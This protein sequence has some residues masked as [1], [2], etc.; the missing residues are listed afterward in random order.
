MSRG[1]TS[2]AA[3]QCKCQ[4]A[5][6]A[7]GAAGSRSAVASTRNFCVDLAAGHLRMGDR[8]HAV[9]R[10]WRFSWSA[11]NAVDHVTRRK[12]PGLDNLCAAMR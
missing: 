4:T 11:L 1:H 3:V 6:V 12:L 8:R 10:S 7:V 2:Y 5:P 9:C